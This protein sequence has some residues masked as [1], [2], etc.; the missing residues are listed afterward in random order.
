MH[1]DFNPE[2]IALPPELEKRQWLTFEEFGALAGVS[3]VTVRSWKRKGIV[4]VR[5]FTPRCNRIPVSEVERL[6]RG[7]LMEGVKTKTK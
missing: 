3:A 7:E 2:D 5:Q 6:K 1:N 4:K